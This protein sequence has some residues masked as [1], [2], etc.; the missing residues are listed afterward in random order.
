MSK[1]DPHIDATSGRTSRVLVLACAAVVGACC[2]AVLCLPL[3]HA[4]FPP[5]FDPSQFDDE[6]LEP[7]LRRL[8]RFDGG[9][10]A[11]LVES[12][13]ST[14][15]ALRLAAWRVVHEMIDEALSR[16]TDERAKALDDVAHTLSAGVAR[17]NG[18][19]L[20]LAADIASRLIAVADSRD[21]WPGRRIRD[22]HVVLAAM[23][24]AS[25]AQRLQERSHGRPDT[26]NQISASPHG[27]VR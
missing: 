20:R 10:T 14:R 6:E 2:G 16:P 25:L 17:L 27:V 24:H 13:G 3:S 26:V 8:R 11:I 21:G 19:G 15:G 1:S 12:L 4:R 22:C 9:E 18:E 23:A 7:C 5:S